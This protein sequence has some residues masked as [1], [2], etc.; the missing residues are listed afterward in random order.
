TGRIYSD[1]P[2]TLVIDLTGMT[3]G[4]I[5]S[6]NELL[7]RHPKLHGQALGTQVR[8]VVLMSAN[9]LKTGP[10]KPGPDC[11]RRLQALGDGELHSVTVDQLSPVLSDQELLD[12]VK[13]SPGFAGDTLD[14]HG[15]GHWRNLLFGGLT[16]DKTGQPVFQA[17]RLADLAENACLELLDAPWDEPEFTHTLA[18][19]LRENGFFANGEWVTLK[20]GITLTRKDTSKE[21]LAWLFSRFTQKGASPAHVP[22]RPMV[23]LNRATLE[24]A[25][26][27]NTLKNGH[28]SR[29]NTLED[30]LNGCAQVS[31]TDSLTDK[32]WLRLLRRLEQLPHPPAVLT[33]H[34]FTRCPNSQVECV[35]YQKR[36]SALATYQDTHRIYQMTAQDQWESLWF[37]TQ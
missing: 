9:M 26:A 25:L 6:L 23:Y 37:D 15:E 28:P 34:S 11:W 1:T 10:N 32:Q 21:E 17:G 27:D 22:S 4:Q 12:G 5:A 19:A 24:D 18:T 30:L 29:T 36:A 35:Q 14:F 8:R 3:P 31:V 33:G 2:L 20:N 13:H 7:D 16:L